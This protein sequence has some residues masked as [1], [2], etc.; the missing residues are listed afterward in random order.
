MI[1]RQG[2][3]TRLSEKIGDKEALTSWSC[4]SIILSEIIPDFENC[5]GLIV[6]HRQIPSLLNQADEQRDLLR[7]TSLVDPEG[8][9]VSN[10]EAQAIKSWEWDF[11]SGWYVSEFHMREMLTPM[12]ETIIEILGK[13]GKKTFS[14]ERLNWK[15]KDTVHARIIAKEW[16]EMLALVKMD[17]EEDIRLGPARPPFLD[18]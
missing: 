15:D 2:F 10:Y 1:S 4:E 18:L 16:N 14:L 5:I 7:S 11:H 3:P 6:R 17:N 9:V 13:T 8:E 12:V